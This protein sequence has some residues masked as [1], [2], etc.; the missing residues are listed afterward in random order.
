MADTETFPYLSAFAHG[1]LL[2]LEKSQASTLFFAQEYYFGQIFDM[3]NNIGEEKIN[4]ENKTKDLNFIQN[5]STLL[6]ITLQSCA[7]SEFLFCDFEWIFVFCDFILNLESIE[8][9][10]RYQLT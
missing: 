7:V 1:K 4:D 6:R 8:D 5:M 9:P 2:D 10:K 3:I